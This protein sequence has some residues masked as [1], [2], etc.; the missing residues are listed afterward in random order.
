MRLCLKTG[1]TMEDN[2]IGKR[3]VQLLKKHPQGLTITDIS[4]FL[5][6][7]RNTVTKYIYELSGAGVIVQRRIG[8]AKLCYLD[9]TKVR[10]PR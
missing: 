6:L 10:K 9:D 3:I 4:N 5:G 1:A 8:A 7:N 2:G